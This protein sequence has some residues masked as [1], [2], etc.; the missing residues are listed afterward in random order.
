M[1]NLYQRFLSILLSATFNAKPIMSTRFPL[2]K[3]NI[4]SKLLSLGLFCLIFLLNAEVKAQI[5]NETGH[6]AFLD[7]RN[8]QFATSDYQRQES[9]L[10]AFSDNSSKQFAK[11]AFKQPNL[12]A[13]AT[14]AAA[15]TT[16]A[17]LANESLPVGTL[18]ID[19]FLK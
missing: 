14:A 1:K 5:T 3:D 12:L 2:Y 13:A 17:P 7:V 16:S 8:N 10:V 6:L 18:V 15:A 11:P 9:R 19:H 4:D